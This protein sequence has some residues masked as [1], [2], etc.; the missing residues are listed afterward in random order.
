MNFDNANY[1]LDLITNS[2]KIKL[3]A[4]PVNELKR[5]NKRFT[6][7]TDKADNVIYIEIHNI[8]QILQNKVECIVKLLQKVI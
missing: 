6:I 8:R 1:N 4:E 7:G 3:S 2:L 5:V